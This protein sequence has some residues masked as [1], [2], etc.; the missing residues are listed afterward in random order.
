[1][2]SLVFMKEFYLRK[3]F[4]S[5]YCQVVFILVLIGSY[6]LIPDKVFSGIYI[7]LA[8]AFM[9]VFSLVITCF[10]REIKDKVKEERRYGASILSIVLGVIGFSAFQVCGVGAPICGASLGVV[11][12]SS[13]FPSFFV[14]F[15]TAYSN[16]ILVGV[17]IVQLAALI[18]M[19]CFKRVRI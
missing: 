15:L 19:G 3:I 18:Y 2:R 7:G 16:L 1:M 17:I 10:V 14:N 13:I 9:V 12:V 5:H 8:L 6:F 11:F 4:R